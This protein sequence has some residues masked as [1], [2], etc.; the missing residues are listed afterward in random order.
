MQMNYNL[1]EWDLT[2]SQLQVLKYLQMHHGETM[3]KEIEREFQVSHPTIVGLVSRLEKNGFVTTRVDTKDR[4]NK[5]VSLTDKAREHHKIIENEKKQN[6]AFL[7]S[8]LSAEDQQNLR[9]YLL[10][11]QQNLMRNSD[12][13]RNRAS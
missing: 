12:S 10:L 13:S 3:Q 11:I 5:I 2:F 9:R 4:R 1:K 8:G 6:E 7:L